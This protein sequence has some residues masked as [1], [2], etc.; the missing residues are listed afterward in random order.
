MARTG[1]VAGPARGT[2]STSAC[3]SVD[4][5]A[6]SGMRVPWSAGN[7]R[8]LTSGQCSGGLGWV[9]LSAGAMS[10]A[11]A[12]RAVNGAPGTPTFT[13]R[14]DRRGVAVGLVDD[15]VGRNPR[16]DGDR[17]QPAPSRSKPKP[18]CPTGSA[19][20]GGT[21]AGGARGHRCRRV[22][23]DDDEQRVE[24][25]RTDRRRRR[26]DRRVD[27]GQQVLP[28]DQRRGRVEVQTGVSMLK[29]GACRCGRDR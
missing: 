14:A 22:L 7:G 28:G 4:S 10:A 6:S 8:G 1:R 29:A 21:A 25:V 24:P 11:S 17:G 2:P 16:R 13:Q 26:A 15:G 18:I 3:A 20:S 5:G 12:S 19:G 9:R 23:E 27:P